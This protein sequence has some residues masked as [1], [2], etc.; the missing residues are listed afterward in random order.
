MCL[1]CDMPPELN[2][3]LVTLVISER[4]KRRNRQLKKIML[5]QLTTRCHGNRQT[6]VECTVVACGEYI[7]R[8]RK[9]TGLGRI[10]SKQ[11]RRQSFFGS[12]L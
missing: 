3:L 8:L 7:M 2:M 6:W 10:R 1:A 9:D 5:S 11:Q 12:F 4:G